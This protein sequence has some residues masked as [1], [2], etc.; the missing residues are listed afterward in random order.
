MGKMHKNYKWEVLDVTSADGT[1]VIEAISGEPSVHNNSKLLQD[2]QISLNI[3][4]NGNDFR[5]TLKFRSRVRDGV[6]EYQDENPENY[7]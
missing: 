3:R 1:A 2:R 7:K 5:E 6:L 4:C